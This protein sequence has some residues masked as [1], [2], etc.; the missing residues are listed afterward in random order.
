MPK[1]LQIN[2]DNLHMKFSTLNVKLNGPSLDPV[3]SEWPATRALK[4]GTP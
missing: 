3:D 1:S 4:M 2:Q